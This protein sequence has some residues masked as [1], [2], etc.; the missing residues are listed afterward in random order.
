MSKHHQ[1]SSGTRVLLG[2]L[3]GPRGPELTC[4]ECFELLDPYVELELA[5]APA[6]SRAHG[7]PADRAGCY[8]AVAAAKP[9]R[10]LWCAGRQW[11]SRLA[12]AFDAPRTSVIITTP[13]SP[14]NSRPT[15]RGTR[16]GFL[17]PSS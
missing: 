14:A 4:E 1:D 11:S 3:L 2:R 13:A 15:N 10:Q 8:P 5:E 16:I 12:L 7:A 9:C 6:E 17:A